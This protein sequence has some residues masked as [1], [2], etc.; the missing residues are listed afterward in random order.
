MNLTNRIKRLSS[1]LKLLLKGYPLSTLDVAKR[2]VVSKKIIQTNFKDY[3]IPLFLD[4]KI[5]YYYSEKVYKASN[6]FLT[7][8]LFNAKELAVISIL[9]FK[10]KDEDL[11]KKT[12]ALFH[13]FEYELSNN[14]YQQSSIAKLDE[15]KEEIIQ[16]K[17]A[18]KTKNIIKC[19]YNSIWYFGIQFK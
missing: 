17:N 7:K 18:I 2:F 16:I 9:K 13:K 6:N 19:F 11:F 8:T 12:D 10:F 15:F 1:I 5:K 3:I 4:E 14:I